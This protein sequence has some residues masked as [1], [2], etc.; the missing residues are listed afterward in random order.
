MVFDLGGFK[1]PPC[2]ECKMLQYRLSP[3]GTL[4][5]VLIGIEDGKLVKRSYVVFHTPVRVVV[6]IANKYF[7]TAHDVDIGSWIVPSISITE[8]KPLRVDLVQIYD[9][10]GLLAELQWFKSNYVSQYRLKQLHRIVFVFDN[11]AYHGKRWLLSLITVSVMCFAI[12]GGCRNL[13]HI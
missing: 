12:V 7:F 5:D 11:R 1:I 9:R 8:K 4:F 13:H 2:F 10:A 3:I 6:P